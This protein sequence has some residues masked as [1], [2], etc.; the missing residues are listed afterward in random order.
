MASLVKVAASAGASP[1]N[2]GAQNPS[3]KQYGLMGGTWMRPVRTWIVKTESNVKIEKKKLPDPPCVICKG[4]GKVKC[5][6]CAGRGRTNFTE[7]AMLPKGEWPKWC[8]DC[9][10][11]GRSYCQR[12]FGTGEKRGI[13]GFH[14]PEEEITGPETNGSQN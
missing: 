4:T 13:I 14:V 1:L 8:W 10:G 12:C 3:D 5:N 6:K 2:S 7:L 9:S 11:C